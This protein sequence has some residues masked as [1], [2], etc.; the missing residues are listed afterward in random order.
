MFCSFI[1]MNKLENF[2][3]KHAHLGIDMRMERTDEQKKNNH[4]AQIHKEA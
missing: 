4:Q 1:R 2:G 3:L